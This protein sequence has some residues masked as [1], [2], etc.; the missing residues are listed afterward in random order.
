MTRAVLL[1]FYGTLARA[2]T[3]GPTR[4]EFLEARGFTVPEEVHAR[5][6]DDSIDGLEHLEH[7]RSA[8]HYRRWERER[9]LRFVLECGV[10]RDDAEVLLDDLYDAAKS[11]E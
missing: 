2:T 1:D 8:E 4:A 3:W 10:G 7:S 11:F 5:A 6:R 9:L